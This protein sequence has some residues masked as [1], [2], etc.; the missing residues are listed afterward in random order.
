MPRQLKRRS[1][2]ISRDNEESENES[3][4]E[5]PRRRQRTPQSV[6]SGSQDV[7]DAEAADSQTTEKTLIKKA[8]RLA[9][10]S[11][12]ARK[13][14]RRAEITE[15][16]KN[17]S[18]S[19]R[20]KN[21]NTVFNGAQKTLRDVFGMELVGL[22]TK[23]KTGLNDRR[24]AASQK[25]TQAATQKARSQKEPD[26]DALDTQGRRS[27]KDPV[28][29]AQSWIL[30]ST[31]PEGYKVRQE[32]LVPTRAPDQDTEATYTAICNIIV[33]LLYLHT[34]SGHEDYDATEPISDTRLLR[35]LQRLGLR[36][37]APTGPDGSENI[38]KLFA[39]LERQGYVEKRKD[40]STGEELVE[41]VVGPRGK[42]EIGREGAARFVRA[43]YG[44][45]LD[46]R[47]PGLELPEAGQEEDDT[48]GRRPLKIER[49]ELER[50][51]KRTLGDVVAL[52]LDN[53]AGDGII[54]SDVTGE[55][56]ANRRVR[57]AQATPAR[58][59]GRLRRNDDQDE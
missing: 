29:S 28:A 52:K 3:E 1:E 21:F 55:R 4:Q 23:E 53:G 10:S 44:F 26:I 32:L 51:L 30:I 49:D 25:A 59:S 58:R 40:N 18:G 42:R 41:W 22:P 36:E 35:H 46:G 31:L 17:D 16:L 38:D 48:Q 7:S 50:R 20:G 27:A 47:G 11:E 56:A 19:G 9:L 15:I 24:K 6:V 37:F 2:A 33:A 45:G 8:V 13:P 5:Q 57:T 43:M 34:P 12:Y 39:K 14:V 54:E